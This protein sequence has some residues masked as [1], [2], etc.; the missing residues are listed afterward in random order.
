M[1]CR[2][3][4]PVAG[5]LLNRNTIWC[6]NQPHHKLD[7]LK[8]EHQ[9][10]ET[11]CSYGYS[12]LHGCHPVSSC[13]FLKL[14][15]QWLRHYLNS[16]AYQNGTSYDY[17]QKKTATEKHEFHDLDP[18]MEAIQCVLLFG[19]LCPIL[20]KYPSSTLMQSPDRVA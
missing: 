9:Y 5:G 3:L 16:R 20:I 14:E 1:C 7:F 18:H 10:S 12:Y 11:L 17:C 6:S 13:I 19:L 8:M 2:A 4:Y 15:H